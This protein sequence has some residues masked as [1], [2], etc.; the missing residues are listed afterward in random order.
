MLFVKIDAHGHVF[1]GFCHYCPEIAIFRYP[2][3]LLCLG[4]DREESRC[5]PS[6]PER[7]MDVHRASF[8]APVMGDSA[9][10]FGVQVQGDAPF[11]F[12][13]DDFA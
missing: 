8:K 4:G 1:F 12:P 5:Y 9:K 6:S 10:K 11:N 13:N 2:I 3:R 7:R